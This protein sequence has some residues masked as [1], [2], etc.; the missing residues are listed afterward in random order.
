MFVTRYV[1]LFT[2]YVS[3][4]NTTMKVLFLLFSGAIVYVIRLREP[5]KSSYDKSHDTFLHYKFAVL[6]CAI[7]ALIFNESFEVLE[8]R[9]SVCPLAGG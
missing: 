2:H 5:F 9:L 8:V 3:L 7:L 6:P 4:Y 1:D